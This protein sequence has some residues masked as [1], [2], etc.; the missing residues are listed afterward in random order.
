MNCWR[1]SRQHTTVNCLSVAMLPKKFLLVQKRVILAPFKSARRALNKSICAERRPRSSFTGIS[2]GNC[3]FVANPLR[4][5]QCKVTQKCVCVCVQVGL[6]VDGRGAGRA[7][8]CSSYSLHRKADFTATSHHMW[9]CVA[10]EEKWLFYE[11]NPPPENVFNK[12]PR[13]VSLL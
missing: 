5:C 9:W 1:K 13:R 6:W 2:C 3:Y 8:T 7:V 4:S 12:F 11:V 10:C